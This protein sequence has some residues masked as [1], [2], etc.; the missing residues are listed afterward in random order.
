MYDKKLAPIELKKSLRAQL[1]CKMEEAKYMHAGIRDFN[2]S[3]ASDLVDAWVRAEMPK[4]VCKIQV[5]QRKAEKRQDSIVAA[6][7]SWQSCDQQEILADAFV[8]MATMFSA[9]DKKGNRMPNEKGALNFLI[10][11]LPGEK[12]QKVKKMLSKPARS[13]SPSRPR[14]PAP[15]PSALKQ[16]KGKGKGKGKKGKD[17]G[18][19]KGKGK[20][21]SK[22]P[23]RVRFDNTG[24]KPNKSKPKSS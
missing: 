13:R 6:E 14:S 16:S 21:R 22:S 1:T 3:L 23:G 8:E 4:V 12:Q 10:Q 7:S 2:L 18:K 20:G 9:G 19:D 24:D 15:A 5:D 11:K 17:Q